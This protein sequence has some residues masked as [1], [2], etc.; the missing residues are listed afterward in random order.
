[1]V[2]SGPGGEYTG[3]NTAADPETG[4]I[5]P[6]EEDSAAVF[7]PSSDSG[8]EILASCILKY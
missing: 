5:L 3:D 8:D 2:V 1:V 7:A 6:D 4:L